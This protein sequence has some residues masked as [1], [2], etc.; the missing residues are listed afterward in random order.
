[1]MQQQGSKTT[2]TVS[3]QKVHG[4][5]LSKVDPSNLDEFKYGFPSDGLSSVSYKWWGESSSNDSRNSE[6]NVT[7]ESQDKKNSPMNSV[8][9]DVHSSAND[10]DGCEK[11]TENRDIDIDSSG[12]GSLTALRKKAVEEGQEALRLGL[13]QRHDIKW[14]HQ[15]EKTSLL[16][17]FKSELPSEWRD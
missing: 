8:H 15:S 6:R 10:G 5:A 2:Q 17:V 1:M 3:P 11:K 7:E 4:A 13:H 12:T 9:S 14:L 16:H